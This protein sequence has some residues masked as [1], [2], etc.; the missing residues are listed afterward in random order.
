MLAQSRHIRPVL[1]ALLAC[2]VASWMA[3]DASACA[4]MVS[5][6]PLSTCCCCASATVET[7]PTGP[8]AC[9]KAPIGE[10][11]GCTA[12]SPAVPTPKPASSSSQ[13]RVDHARIV[14]T[15]SARKLDAARVASASHVLP[16]AGVAETPL[17][18]RNARILI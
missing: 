15:R 14:E 16:S 3:R 13:P 10:A 18:L 12:P 2:G 17:Y 1:L 8:S 5:C 6:A 4:T 11:C 9:P 7:A